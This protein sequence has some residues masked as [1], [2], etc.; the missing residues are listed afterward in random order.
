MDT[1]KVKK[2]T[3]LSI[4]TAG[5]AGIGFMLS[6]IAFRNSSKTVKIIGTLAIMSASG[7][8]GYLLTDFIRVKVFGTPEVPLQN[9]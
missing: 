1:I 7:I 2:Y 5:A 4:G 8:G 9:H 3:T 6:R